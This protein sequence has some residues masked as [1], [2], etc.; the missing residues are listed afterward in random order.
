[1]EGGGMEIR[2][3]LE[4]ARV[5]AVVGLSPNPDRPSNSVARYLMAQGYRVIPVNPRHE[6]ILGEKSYKN[7]AEIP[8]KVDV[9]DIFMRAERVI[10][11]VQE[12]ITLN[13]QAIWLQL[14]IVNDE[15][16]QLAE[17]GRIPFFQDLCIK[18]EH[19]RLIGH[20]VR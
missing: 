18:I 2:E 14:G 8:E 13:P 1:M 7:L 6:V 16:K 12:A 19:A 11:I 3:V 20:P 9:V 15:A 4:K 5:I 17:A 10:P